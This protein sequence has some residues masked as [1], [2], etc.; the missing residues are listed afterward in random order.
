VFQTKEGTHLEP[1][2]HVTIRAT[3][4]HSI[5]LYSLSALHL[6]ANNNVSYLCIFKGKLHNEELH[7]L[8]SSPDIIIRACRKHGGEEDCI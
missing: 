3:N 2:E 8:Y 5:S 7:N 1:K 4:L 6:P